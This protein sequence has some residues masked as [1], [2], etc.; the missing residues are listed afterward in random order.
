MMIRD[1]VFDPVL[2]IA[3]LDLELAEPFFVALALQLAIGLGL[4]GRLVALLHGLPPPASNDSDGRIN[5]GSCTEARA[6]V[7]GR[8]GRGSGL[9][10][11]AAPRRRRQPR[12]DLQCSR[13]TPLPGCDRRLPTALSRFAPGA[14]SMLGLGGAGVAREIVIGISVAAIAVPGGL[15]LAQLMGLPSEA[16]LYACIVPTLVYALFGSFVALH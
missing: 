14:Y 9:V 6:P 5:I 3:E 8:R 10:A 2:Q 16:G 12:P 15:A 7:G 1:P 4:L 11:I 13:P